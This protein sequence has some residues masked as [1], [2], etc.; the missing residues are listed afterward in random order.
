MEMQNENLNNQDPQQ[1]Q[2]N[3]PRNQYEDQNKDDKRNGLNPDSKLEQQP[4]RNQSGRFERESWTEDQE[5]P[6]DLPNSK[7]QDSPDVEG[8]SKD[9]Q[10]ISQQ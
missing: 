8:L 9:D 4:F 6:N 7:N 1:E 10:S 2:G 5:N 3:H